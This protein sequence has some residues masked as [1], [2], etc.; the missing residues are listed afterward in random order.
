[1]LQQTT[2]IPI[3]Y[4]LTGISYPPFA[5]PVADNDYDRTIFSIAEN[6][7]VTVILAYD[8]NITS[9]GGTVN[10]PNMTTQLKKVDEEGLVIVPLGIE[11]SVPPDIALYNQGL[12]PQSLDFVVD[13]T[14]KEWYN[15]NLYLKVEQ[16][17]D[18]ILKQGTPVLKIMPLMNANYQFNYKRFF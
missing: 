15:V 1:M 4:K 14:M 16:A 6:F 2:S 5:P 13:R 3:N 9:T 8:V 18:Y 7:G 10:Q 12:L 11:L 17:D